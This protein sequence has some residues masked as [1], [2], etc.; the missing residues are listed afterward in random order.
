MHDAYALNRARL[1]ELAV[2]L[3]QRFLRT[4][5]LALPTLKPP[6]QGSMPP[7]FVS[8][9]MYD[10]RTA[11]VHIWPYLCARPAVGVARAWSFPGFKT[12]RT[13]VGVL[14]HETGHHIDWML[15]LTKPLASR[16]WHTREMKREAVSSYEPCAAEAVAETLRVFILNPDLLAAFAPTR[17][18]YLRHVV[19]LKPSEKRDAFTVLSSW[20]AKPSFIE[21]AVVQSRCDE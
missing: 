4:N 9:G 14:A 8:C 11:S 17:Y 2:P 19:G 13:P 5:G 7:H 1:L 15:D 6:S 21:A 18:N 16:D 10:P 12:D 3:V 20:N